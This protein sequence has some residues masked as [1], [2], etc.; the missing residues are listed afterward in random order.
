MA[1]IAH[2]QYTHGLGTLSWFKKCSSRIPSFSMLNTYTLD[3]SPQKAPFVF[4][5]S[6][7][8]M[9]SPCPL[10]QRALQT[11][12]AIAIQK[13]DQRIYGFNFDHLVDQVIADILD[14]RIKVIQKDPTIFSD[15][16]IQKDPKK[17]PQWIAVHQCDPLITIVLVCVAFRSHQ[18]L[19]L[20]SSD[21]DPIE[22]SD[23][24]IDQRLLFE[25]FRGIDLFRIFL[26]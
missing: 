14:R 10:A 23:E 21:R 19:F 24:I 2:P 17:I 12:T 25:H 26:A 22:R 1:G 3:L 7:R 4:S 9:M 5:Q 18:C 8:S 20:A 11:P 13:G 16:K 6:T 15:Q